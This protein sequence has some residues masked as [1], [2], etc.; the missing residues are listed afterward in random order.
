MV[1]VDTQQH[2]EKKKNVI[3]LCF[4]LCFTLHNFTLCKTAL[5]LKHIQKKGEEKKKFKQHASEATEHPD[6]G[7][8]FKI[9]KI[10]ISNQFSR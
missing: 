8:S 1:F 4:G 5:Q 10:N 7:F 6:L 3:F 2:L 9:F